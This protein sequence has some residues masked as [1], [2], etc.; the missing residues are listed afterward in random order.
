M[1]KFS[2]KI[3][4]SLLSLSLLPYHITVSS[5]STVQSLDSTEQVI[6]MMSQMYSID[7]N[8]LQDKVD[9]GYSLVDLKNA[10]VIKKHS[11]QSL[12]TILNNYHPDIVNNSQEAKS[13][14]TSELGGN[15]NFNVLVDETNPATEVD[16]SKLLANITVKEEAPYRVSLDQESISTISGSLSYEQEDAYLPGRNGMSFSLVRTYNSQ[17][18][19]FDDMKIGDSS[20][21]DYFVI[22]DAKLAEYQQTYVAKTF[23]REYYEI[24]YGCD[25]YID[26]SGANSGGYYVDSPAYS[27]T[28]G[29]SN[30]RFDPVYGSWSSC[31]P[32]YGDYPD[33]GTQPPPTE[34]EPEPEPEE[35]P[36]PY[37]PPP[38]CRDQDL[39]PVSVP[40]LNILN[41]SERTRTVKYPDYPAEII[42]GPDVPT[43]EELNKT[44]Y[45][46]FSTYQEAQ[47]K[48]IQINN[49]LKSNQHY[50]ID[51]QYYY[52]YTSA[53]VIDSAVVDYQLYN[54]VTQ[55][56]NEK[57][58]PIGKGWSWNIPFVDHKQVDGLYKPFLYMD[59]GSVY[60]IDGSTLKGY[61]WKDL[62]FELDNSINTSEMKSK[63]VLKTMEGKNYYFNDQGNV[64]VISNSYGNKI[65]FNYQNHYKYGN[66][67][68]SI[69]DEIGNSINIYYSADKVEIVNGDASKK[70][71]YLKTLSEGKEVLSQVV[72]P[73]GLAT[74]YDYAIKPAQ[75]N[76][77]GSTPVATNPYA[78]LT[79]I[80]H[81]TGAVT[82]YEY[83]DTPVKRYM[84][85][86][87]VNQAY[88]VKKRSDYVLLS[89]GA[90]EYYNVK[91]ISY[92]GDMGSAAN[93]D[94]TFK[95]TIDNKL[96]KTTHSIRK[97][98]INDATPPIFY[99]DEVNEKAGGMSKNTKFKYDEVKRNP[100]PIETT[101]V[102]IKDPVTSTGTPTFSKA[103][104]TTKQFNDY[105]RA[106]T[107][108]DAFKTVS[109][110]YDTYD[111]TLSDSIFTGAKFKLLVPTQT[112]ETIYKNKN[113][114]DETLITNFE[115]SKYSNGNIQ[116]Q[117]SSISSEGTLLSK[118]EAMYNLNGNLG[119]FIEHNQSQTGT[120][121]PRRK[122]IFTY[123]PTYNQAYIQSISEEVTDAD[124][125]KQ[126]IRKAFDYDKDTG[127]PIE[128]TDGNGN[129]TRYEYD[130]LDRIKK[131]SYIDPS[132]TPDKY[133][134]VSFA[135]D[136]FK[137]EIITTN[138]IGLKNKQIWNP[139]GWK[140]E[141]QIFEDNVFKI[142]KKMSY[143][144]VGRVQL[145]SDARGNITTFEYDSWSRP[146]NTYGA[147]YQKNPS[148]NVETGS[149][150]TI[151]YDD[152]LHK[153][154]TTDLNQNT[155]EEIYD[156][157][158]RLLS[159]TKKW[160]YNGITKTNKIEQYTYT[161]NDY[162]T[163]NGKG[164][165]TQYTQDA[166]DRLTSV[167]YP[168]GQVLAH[169]ETTSYKY[170][171]MGNMIQIT[172]PDNNIVQKEYDE[173]GR[174]I[175]QRDPSGYI[176]KNFYDGNNNLVRH[177]DKK[178]NQFI[179]LY[180]S[181][182]LP[183]LRQAYTG[184]TLVDQIEMQYN[185]A[186][187]IT[188]MIAG[189]GTNTKTTTYEYYMAQ[190]SEPAK[191]AGAL[192]KITQPDGS[193]YQYFYNPKGD[194]SK[195]VVAI[196]L[197]AP[198]SIDYTY[199]SL[200]RMKTVS[201]PSKAILETYTYQN[202]GL[203]N[204][205]VRNNYSE[206]T[207]TYDGV[208][209]D[210]QT[211]KK[212][213]DLSSLGSYSVDYDMNENITSLVS[214]GKNSTYNYDDINRI[215]SSSIKNEAYF[216][217]LRGNRETLIGDQSINLSRMEYQY[218]NWDRLTRVVK[219]NGQNVEY[220]YNGDSL[221]YERTEAGVTTR[222][223]YDGQDIIAEGTVKPDQTVE[224][225][226][227]YIRGANGLVARVSE[228]ATEKANY[229]GVAY[230]H[231]NQ[232]GDVTSLRDRTGKVLNSYE[233]DIWG[234]IQSAGTTETIPNP[235]TY[236]GEYWDKSTS[237]Q[238]LRARWYDP[239]MGRFISED[240]YE[241]EIQNPLS[242]NLY[243]Y[244]E[245]NP[246][247]Y[248]DPSGMSPITLDSIVVGENG[249]G[250]YN[251][252]SGNLFN[253]DVKKVVDQMFT[254]KEE[255][256]GRIKLQNI[257]Y[258]ELEVEKNIN[259]IMKELNGWKK[260]PLEQSI[261]HQNSSIYNR[262]YWKTY[263]GFQVEVVIRE[264][265]GLSPN[266]VYNHEDIGTLNYGIGILAHT[267]YD[268]FPYW[269]WGNS[270][271]DRTAKLNRIVGPR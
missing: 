119:E 154:S 257:F 11:N 262:K 123:H 178:G 122:Q 121:V 73:T 83:E 136:D 151:V 114:L 103:V 229:G 198:W 47:A 67:L 259:Q 68:S 263:K 210:Q 92:E 266:I 226:A 232:H 106:S 85:T 7:V 233:Y 239:S 256:Y 193:T 183:K 91:E 147:D 79:A 24:D 181:R 113:G 3:L 170:D 248:T 175:K 241:G 138:E 21:Y 235:F 194:R 215:T 65:T 182:N 254:S 111:I 60:E 144:S 258:E 87:S 64:I 167:T 110:T 74:T 4:A 71:T 174:L 128:F 86:N 156:E 133:A 135:Y 95:T 141:E 88:K 161:G 97:D 240:T 13:E 160:V 98:F 125:V 230:Y 172:H 197:S 134:V 66:V 231:H 107:E 169:A 27:T 9:E 195:L 224:L 187:T 55:S 102:N 101:N 117:I 220:K 203:L 149:K 171:L 77:F 70:V 228:D 162:S 99:T 200:N 189:V 127:L 54:S 19:Q 150:T 50:D 2:R 204:K 212:L 166:F 72:G 192:K 45:Q 201:E 217:D 23:M 199:D 155:L 61:P 268:V 132:R 158:G 34:P 219:E 84:G 78:L 131:V 81:P 205:V 25:G 249:S 247:K 15:Y 223:Y 38:T 56:V 255:H 18:A 163:K 207:L 271:D 261:Y 29:A 37:E 177:N 116:K 44:Y 52:Y 62:T 82:T 227:R 148:T 42:N 43:G 251:Q 120:I 96:T 41:T 36:P 129:K 80:K 179:Y 69:K 130:P 17:D 63:Y 31:T 269:L 57:R 137:N 89:N 53:P 10:L 222:Y 252:K 75:F 59:N 176:E 152:I 165:F 1:K 51:N 90:K 14:I 225:K 33:P 58:F 93:V 211:E 16:P 159:K 20:D 32:I 26:F 238:Y 260:A 218:D 216:Y 242:L 253:N 265:P 124:G 143:D 5:D 48:V 196:G 153:I 22:W 237:L 164:Y 139:L 202:N 191:Y 190:D 214:N 108:T 213:S 250:I 118:N 142:K 188:K 180:T 126:T 39:C 245:N 244:V 140:T 157:F 234:N 6:Q 104:T 146:T 49:Y 12:E 246:L 46:V 112:T 270:P 264:V 40:S 185:D 8:E 100:S 35:P 267:W 243:T 28:T 94:L 168:K 105:G 208:L 186:G 236:S 206:K 30:H 173:A 109:S 221:M 209:L 115:Y 76:L 145:E 184:A